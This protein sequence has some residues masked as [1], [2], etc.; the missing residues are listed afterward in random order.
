MKITTLDGN[1]VIWKLTG[2][3]KNERVNQ[4]GPHV[5]CKKLLKEV[6]P[7]CQ[8]LEEIPIPVKNNLQLYLDFYIPLYSLAIEVNGQQHY[9]YNKYYHNNVIGFI[10]QQ[11]NDKLKQ[12]WCKLNYIQLILLNDKDNVDQWKNQLSNNM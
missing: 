9:S 6:F 4:S 1:S 2:F 7:T 3:V 11:K 8:I 10:K 5:L 12:E